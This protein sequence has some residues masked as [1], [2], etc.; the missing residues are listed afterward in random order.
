MAARIDDVHHALP[1]RAHQ[2]SLA[3]GRDR[4]ALGAMRDRDGAGDAARGGIHHRDRALGLERGEQLTG[5]MTDRNPMRR[6]A[7]IDALDFAGVGIDRQ[8]RGPK[9]GGR[10]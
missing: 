5:R 8:H 1:V 7:D 3:V 9:L 6:A 4:D 2:Q 10:P